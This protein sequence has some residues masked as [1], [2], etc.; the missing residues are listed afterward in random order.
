MSQFEFDMIN[1]MDEKTRKKLKEGEL[2]Q[3]PPPFF[4]TIRSGSG[5]NNWTRL[6]SLRSLQA[7]KYRF[8]KI[9]LVCI[10]LQKG[11]VWGS[12]V[13]PFP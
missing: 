10:P 3:F 8:L 7:P 6:E 13:E 5:W 1:M 9:L 11:K 12:M 2:K 4:L